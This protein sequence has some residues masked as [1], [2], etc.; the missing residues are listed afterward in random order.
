MKYH[1]PVVPGFYPDPSVC[2]VKDTY[3]LVASSFEYFP[4]I[5]I[6]KS[7]DLINW[8]SLGSVLTKKSQLPLSGS[9]GHGG[10]YAPTIRYHNGVFYVVSTNVDHGG[11]FYVTTTNPQEG[12]SEPVYV[13]QEG[14]DPSLFFEGDQAYFL[15]TAQHNGRNTI[16]LSKLNVKNGEVSDG[17]YLWYGNGGRYLEGPHLYKIAGYYYI[18]ASEGGTEYG[19]MLVA[20]RSKNIFGPYESCPNNPILT[21]RDMGGY[22]LQGAGHGDFME[23]INGNWWVIFLAFRQL[24]RYMQFHTLGRE[25][26]L[27]PVDFVNDWPVINSGKAHLIEET[28]R[29]NTCQKAVPNVEQETAKIGQDIFF[30]RNPN[31]DSY[32]LKPDKYILTATKYGISERNGSPSAVFSRQRSFDD[33]FSVKVD[34]QNCEAGITVYLEPDQHYDLLVRK[35]ADSQFEAKVSLVIGPAHSI[36][37]K[38]AFDCPAN[39]LPQLRITCSN[40]YYSFEINC[41]GQKYNLGSYDAHYLSS[42]VAGDF[43][44]VMLGMFVEDNSKN[45]KAIFSDFEIDR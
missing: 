21:N 6:F 37:K 26:C 29:V 3:Y 22:Q 39:L 36:T 14:I 5:P 12:W 8:T 45:G 18:L 10:I 24:D 28:N 7:K 34:P 13:D 38:V 15:S 35:N 1:N 11:H 4:G 20:A 31:F 32:I 42:E 2:K 17:H 16:L 33:Q 40:K 43:T 9:D 44:G 25:I 30:L 41:N 23:D 19:H 27:E